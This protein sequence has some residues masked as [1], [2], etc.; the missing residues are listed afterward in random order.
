MTAL[1][2]FSFTLTLVH[3]FFLALAAP[4]FLPGRAPALVDLPLS[5][6]A[7]F[8]STFLAYKSRE[9]RLGDQKSIKEHAIHSLRGA[10]RTHG[11]L[12]TYHI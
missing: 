9:A 1:F 3:D 11:S 12:T 4:V 2:I 7:S 6:L 5:P 10:D 8:L